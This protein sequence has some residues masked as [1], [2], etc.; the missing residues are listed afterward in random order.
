MNTGKKYTDTFI[1]VMIKKGRKLDFH[2]IHFQR[3]CNN[4]PLRK[5]EMSII[6][7]EIQKLKNKKSIVNTD[8]RTGDYISGIFTRGKKDGSHSMIL[9]LKN[10]NKFICCRHFKME[11]I[12]NGL[13]V[14]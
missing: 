4:L 5:Q 8:K 9:N 13:N 1:P 2:E 7:S 6:N 14:F 3:C 10:F 12:Q 11:S